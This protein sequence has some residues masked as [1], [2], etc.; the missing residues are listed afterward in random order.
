M[1]NFEQH[2]GGEYRVFQR[3]ETCQKVLFV[4]TGVYIKS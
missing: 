4:R 3:L 2:G 1:K